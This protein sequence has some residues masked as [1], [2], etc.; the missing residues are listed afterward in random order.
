MTFK[1]KYKILSIFAIVS[2]FI[3]VAYAPYLSFRLRELR[4]N[5]IKKGLQNQLNHVDFSLNVFFE[6]IE[7]DLKKI[8]LN[9]Y[10]VSVDI[11]AFRMND[12]KPGEEPDQ[13]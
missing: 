1:I 6:E 13:A 2:I 9:P 10:V 3:L 11:L 8:I 12:W 7:H 4:I 5:T